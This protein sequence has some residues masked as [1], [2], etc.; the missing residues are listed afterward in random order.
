MD[1][2][3]GGD[4]GWKDWETWG[5]DSV[6]NVIWFFVSGNFSTFSYEKPGVIFLSVLRYN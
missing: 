2:F 6:E 4:G 5:A 3:Y 1:G